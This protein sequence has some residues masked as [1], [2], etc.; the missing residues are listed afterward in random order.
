[1]NTVQQLIITLLKSAVTGEGLSL[2]EG[3]SLADAC[4][5][6]KKQGL[7]TLA[8]EGAVHCG[9]SRTDPVM[10]ELFPYY[11]KVLLH[12]ERQMAKVNALLGE[13]E[14]AGIDYLPFKGCVMKALYPKPELRPMGDADIL[15]RMEQYDRIIPILTE[16][17]FRLEIESDCELI[18]KHPDLYLELHKCMVQPSHKDYYG[19]FGDG[20]G[21]SVLLE[22]HRYGFV[23]EDMY[24][25]LF[26]H[27]AKHYRSGGIGCRHVVDLWVYRR[28]NGM[29]DWNYVNRELKKLHLEQF[30][31]HCERLLEAWFEDGRTD[32]M[33][34]FISKRIFS[35]GSWGKQEDYQIFCEL[36]KLKET[37]KIR[38]S[39]LRYAVYLAFPPLIQ[40]RKKYPILHRLPFLL[41]AAWVLRGLTVLLHKRS[42]LSHAVRNGR[43]IDD[44]ALNAHQE[45][46]RVVG[47]EWH[48]QE[49]SED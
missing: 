8:Y 18:W 15:I 47:L 36:L 33:T 37:D 29:L 4:E 21:R 9:V 49:Y 5:I 11:Y 43:I 22:G 42:K 46:L 10:K 48:G 20:W 45:A 17:G 19:Y 31:K 44:A 35:G 23:P 32:E 6:I 3:V 25:Y 40:I 16:L 26:M 2:P 14:K 28:V 27:F 30:H 1:M 41:P 34:E 38:N 12:S 24:V 13:F 39:R 7:V